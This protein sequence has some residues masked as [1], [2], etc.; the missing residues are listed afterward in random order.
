MSKIET[1]NEVLA[2]EAE[3]QEKIDKANAAKISKIQKAQEEA[4]E[5]MEKAEKNAVLIKDGAV[6]SVSER[7][8]RDSKHKLLEARKRAEEIEW[9]KLGDDAASEI[10]DEAVRKLIGE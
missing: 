5:I 2:A 8:E 7:I 9:S 1:I 4:R 10:A 3:A 6:R